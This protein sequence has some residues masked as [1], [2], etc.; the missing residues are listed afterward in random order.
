[1]VMANQFVVRYRQISSDI[2]N[3]NPPINFCA[4]LLAII[5][6]QVVQIEGRLSGNIPRPLL[7]YLSSDI[8]VKDKTNLI[9]KKTVLC[10]SIYQQIAPN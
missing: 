10:E 5:L 2:R 9:T 3:Y 7:Q 6:H 8:S 4:V 1:M